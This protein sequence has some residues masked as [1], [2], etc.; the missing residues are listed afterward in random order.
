MYIRGSTLLNIEK[1]IQDAMNLKNHPRIMSLT[2]LDEKEYMMFKE[3][4]E[5]ETIP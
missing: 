5:D 1:Q 2:R 3:K 4:K